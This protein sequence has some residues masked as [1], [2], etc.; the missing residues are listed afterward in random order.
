MHVDVH[1]IKKM[2]TNSKRENTRHDDDHDGVG[3]VKEIRC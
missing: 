2:V 1:K 3:V